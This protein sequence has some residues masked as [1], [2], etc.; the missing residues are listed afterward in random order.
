M[1]NCRLAKMHITK[2]C[3]VISRTTENILTD[4]NLLVNRQQTVGGLST[5]DL[6]LIPPLVVW[7]SGFTRV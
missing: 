1:F 5:V 7:Q 4:E 6:Q 2:A 3:A